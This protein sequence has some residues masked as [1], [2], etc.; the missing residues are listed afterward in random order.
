MVEADLSTLKINTLL[1]NKNSYNL[2]SH[3]LYYRS[4]SYLDSEE[5]SIYL[6]EKEINGYSE[7]NLM[8]GFYNSDSKTASVNLKIV[9]GSSSSSSFMQIGIIV[10]V[11]VAVV[12][13]AAVIT[14]SLCKFSVS[15]LFL[16]FLLDRK[17]RI[18][19][20]RSLNLN[21]GNIEVQDGG[22]EAQEDGQV[23]NRR[24]THPQVEYTFI[25]EF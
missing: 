16:Y 23:I 2:P 18:N 10:G 14:I 22:R 5:T 3:T 25:Y 20:A 1:Q 4:Y 24:R 13:I 19:R 8:I 17:R 11:I 12:V 15:F 21:Q 6:T 9:E 7:G